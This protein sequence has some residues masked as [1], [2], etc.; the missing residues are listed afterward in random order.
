M[1]YTCVSSHNQ[2]SDLGRQI[3]RLTDWASAQGMSISEV[4]TE[5]GSG[6]NGKRRK[7]SCLLSDPIA[8]TIVVEHR[9]RLAR[10][11]VE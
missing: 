1:I 5:V 2:R 3:E 8:S 7:L 4:V 10:F 6:M 11:R 9:D